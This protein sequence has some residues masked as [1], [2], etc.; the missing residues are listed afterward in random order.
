MHVRCFRWF[1]HFG[2]ADLRWFAPQHGEIDTASARFHYCCNPK[3]TGITHTPKETHK[4]SVNTK[5]SKHTNCR[6]HVEAASP[7]IE[8]VGGTPNSSVRGILHGLKRIHD[9]GIAAWRKREEWRRGRTQRIA[10]ASNLV[11]S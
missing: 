8:L 11:S 4:R 5:E 9:H 10:M 1:L 6:E 2:M 3:T 7:P